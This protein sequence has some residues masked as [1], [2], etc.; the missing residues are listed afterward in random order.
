MVLL[1]FMFENLEKNSMTGS[2]QPCLCSNAYRSIL[3]CQN[4]FSMNVILHKNS[5]LAFTASRQIKDEAVKSN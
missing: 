5:I 3:G 4:V 1:M 2:R